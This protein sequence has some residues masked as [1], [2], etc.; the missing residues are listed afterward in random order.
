MY[1]AKPSLPN[2]KLSGYPDFFAPD[3]TPLDLAAVVAESPSLLSRNVWR[4]RLEVIG[5]NAFRYEL[6]LFWCDLRAGEEV[7]SR[8]KAFTARL[9]RV[10][11][12]NA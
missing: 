3:N 12:A 7:R 9:N 2:I 5:E 1:H 4:K 10:I 8:A 11:A 6:Y